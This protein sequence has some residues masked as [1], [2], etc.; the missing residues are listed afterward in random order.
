MHSTLP[1]AGIPI[2][3]TESSALYATRQ[4]FGDERVADFGERV[5]TPTDRHRLA[6][7]HPE[8]F[9]RLAEARAQ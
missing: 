8:Q 2:Q 4:L 7:R 1:I 6:E 5:L 9:T 3:L